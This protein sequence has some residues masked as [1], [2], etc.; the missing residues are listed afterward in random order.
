MISYASLLEAYIVTDAY[1]ITIA[2]YADR[3]M[4]SGPKNTIWSVANE[5]VDGMSKSLIWQTNLWFACSLNLALVSL[6]PS[7]LTCHKVKHWGD[8]THIKL[9]L[10]IHRKFYQYN[11]FHG[12]IKSE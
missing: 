4:M 3:L 12:V 10:E 6:S 11:H 2:T 9:T 7:L 5:C 1:T 8:I